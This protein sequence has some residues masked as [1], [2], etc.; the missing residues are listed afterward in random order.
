M[1]L[2]VQETLAALL[3]GALDEELIYRKRLRRRV[4]EY[5]RNVPP[6]VQAAR[7]L[8]RPVRWI[9]YMITRNGPEPVLRPGTATPVLTMRI[10]VSG[11]LLQ[12]QMAF[13]HFLDTSFAQI[14]DQQ[15]ELF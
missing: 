7:K 14:T 11:S 15:I 12:R 5:T 3:S 1:N 8:G 13:L 2:Y 9:R 10:I 6:H 4:E